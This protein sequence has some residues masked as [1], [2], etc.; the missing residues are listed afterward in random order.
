MSRSQRVSMNDDKRVNCEALQLVVDA[1]KQ[2]VAN[3]KAVLKLHGL[4]YKANSELDT[5]I[6][7]MEMYIKK[8]RQ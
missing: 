6:V 8:H 3:T 7:M 2:N 5:A 4:E 1:A